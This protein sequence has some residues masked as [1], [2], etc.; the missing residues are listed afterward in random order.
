MKNTAK[1]YGAALYDLA[2]EENLEVPILK[3]LL[4]IRQAFID[5]PDYRRMLASPGIPKEE[6]HKLVD[7]AWGGKVNQYTINFMKLLIDKELISFFNE[8]GK[9]Y[10]KLYNV[11]HGIV[12]V[13]VISAVPLSEE[14]T[15]QLSEKLAN[16]L[17]KRI[18]IKPII[19]PNIKG[20]IR[21]DI[22]GKQ[23]DGSVGSHLS[24]LKK[25]LEDRKL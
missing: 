16:Y 19:K 9:E 2:K 12:Q 5:F 23:F 3:D 8:C 24:E 20:G 11:N 6:R 7:D 18:E 10:H 21:L 22:G 1:I 17:G 25:Y 4:P 15:A 13:K 14:Q